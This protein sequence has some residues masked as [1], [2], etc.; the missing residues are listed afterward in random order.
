[1]NK[2][3]LVKFIFILIASI[4]S[5]YFMITTSDS[6]F[7]SMFDLIMI[8]NFLFALTMFM[9]SKRNKIKRNKFIYNVSLIILIIFST[10][11]F[12]YFVYSHISCFFDIHC[13]IESYTFFSII[14][15]IFLFMMILFNFEDIFNKTNKTN[16]VLAISVSLIIIFIHLRYYLDSSFVHRLID[17]NAYHQYSYHYVVQNYVY[18]I[19]MYLIVLIHYNVNKVL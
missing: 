17:N 15:P 19:V 4:I 10:I 5:F 18:F 2:R 11:Y 16:D 14:Y 3:G 13:G 12:L 9:F 1:M 6:G 8:F 7:E